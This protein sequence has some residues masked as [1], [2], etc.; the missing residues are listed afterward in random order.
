MVDRDQDSLIV[1]QSK[2]QRWRF[3]RIRNWWSGPDQQARVWLVFLL[4][5]RMCH[6]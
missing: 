3:H 5:D 6:W 2:G 1:G 4:G